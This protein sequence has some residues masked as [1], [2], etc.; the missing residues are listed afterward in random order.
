[1]DVWIDGS[2]QSIDVW[3]DDINMDQS[4]KHHHHHHHHKTHLPT[5][6]GMMNTDSS[7]IIIIIEEEE[8]DE[9]LTGRFE[10]DDDAMRWRCSD[11][12]MD[13]W[14]DCSRKHAKN[15]A[16]MRCTTALRRSLLVIATLQ[17]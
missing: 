17:S 11:L 6:R 2:E 13:G 15:T 16:L 8:E 14:M 7:R 9:P 3:M 1:M 10:F 4:T 5:M 12:V